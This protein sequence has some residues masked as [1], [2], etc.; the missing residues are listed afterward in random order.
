[1]T[2]IS[3]LIAVLSYAIAL[4]GIMPLFQWLTIGPQSLLVICLAVGVAQ[5]K[6]GRIPVP[7][8]LLTYTTPAATAAD[9]RT[10]PFVLYDH[11][12]TPDFASSAYS[13]PSSLPT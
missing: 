5:D 10:G 8:W 13:L 3:S 7:S 2:A 11:R 1:M 4:C 6:M 9:E 12:S